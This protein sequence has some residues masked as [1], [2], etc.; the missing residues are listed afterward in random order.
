MLKRYL[1]VRPSKGRALLLLV[2]VL[3]IY[4][5]DNLPV[6]LVMDYL[7]YN[8]LIRPILWLL[9]AVLVWTL[10]RARPIAPLKHRGNINWWAFNF[11]VI[12]VVASVIAGFIDGFGKSPYDHS[13]TG[14]AINIFTVGAM[15]IGREAARNC[16]VHNLTRKESFLVFIPIALLITLGS[17]KFEKYISLNSIENAIKFIAQ[18]AAPEFLSNLLATYIA[19]LGGFFPA[20]LYMGTTQAFHWLS[21]VLPNLKWI[22]AALIGIMCPAFSMAGLQAIYLKET[23]ALKKSSQEEEGVVGWVIT[24]LFSIGIIWFSVGVFPIY[25]SV[26]ATGSM[27]PMIKPGDVIL[28]ERITK[29]EDI[30]SL[31]EGDIIQ[32]ERGSILVSHRIIEIVEDQGENK[33]RTKGD[34]NPG[35]DQQLV[36]AKYIKGTIKYVIPKI[37]WLT[38]LIKQEDNLPQEELEF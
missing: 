7:I 16:I 2:A 33:Y 36:E 5:L 35:A 12:F 28:V 6:N 1:P 26:V 38:L 13:M 30:N 21:P 32:F 22:T 37:G 17:Y 3:F 18:Y 29:I 19:F 31:K 8:N 20:L 10:P 24:S 23:K 15:L 9:L 11:A 34:N 4:L 25:P 14:I 27:E